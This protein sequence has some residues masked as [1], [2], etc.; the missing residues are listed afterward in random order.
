MILTSIAGLLAVLNFSGLYSAN[1]TYTP[2]LVENNTA[3]FPSTSNSI[4]SNNPQVYYTIL[5]NYNVEFR[6]QFIFQRLYKESSGYTKDFT[7]T[8][9]DEDTNN[10]CYL[11]NLVGSGLGS[12]PILTNSTNNSLVDG[13]NISYYWGFNMNSYT[14]YH[15]FNSGSYLNAYYN[16]ND[17]YLYRN[18]TYNDVLLPNGSG[19]WNTNLTSLNGNNYV[20]ATLRLNIMNS[21]T[22]NTLL[23]N[24]DDSSYQSGYE[25]GYQTGNSEGYATGRQEGYDEGYS[26]G[27]SEGHSEGY[28]EGIAEGMETGHITEIFSNIVQVGI[29]PINVFL[30]MLNFEVFGINIGAFASGLLTIAIVIIIVRIVVG[31]SASSGGGKNGS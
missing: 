23:A 15:Y 17:I 18:F 12:N 25:T 31:S 30:A 8:I 13:V 2:Q 24:T 7:I 28:A 19:T 27:K 20:Y 21:N 9:R 16:S 29:L 4:N 10:L 1:T 3:S 22:Y 11:M 5:D 6:F 14:Y 26:I